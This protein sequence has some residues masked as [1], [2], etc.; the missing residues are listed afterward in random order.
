M[1]WCSS[2]SNIMNAYFWRGHVQIQN[3]Y[4]SNNLIIFFEKLLAFSLKF[5]MMLSKNFAMFV[6]KLLKNGS[7]FVRFLLRIQAILQKENHM[8]I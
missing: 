6:K 2:K 1:E 5:H 3:T 4:L 7:N 8:Y